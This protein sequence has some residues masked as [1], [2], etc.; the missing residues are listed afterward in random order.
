MAIIDARDLPD[1]SELEADLVIIGAGMAGIAI[2]TELAGANK[3]VAVLEGGG[4]DLDREQQTLYAGSGVMRAP[5]HEDTNIDDYLWQSRVRALG[6]SGHVWGGKCVPLDESD[7]AARDWLPNTGW[8]MTRA[9]LQPY[10]D[11]ACGLLEI[12]LF[13]GS[14]DRPREEGR[15]PIVVNGARE[16]FSAPRYFSPVSGGADRDKFDRFRTAFAEAPNVNV[17]L[18]ANVTEIRRR[19]GARRVSSLGVACLNGR[20][21]TARGRSYVLATGGIENVRLLL[22]S[23]LGN[24][25]DQLGRN[26]MGH[27]TFGAFADDAP[28]SILA[29]SEPTQ[30]AGLYT[31][32][33]RD[34]FHCVL[35]ATLE[36]QRRFGIGNF[37]A[38]LF[39]IES[40]R[41]DGEQA[42]FRL[43]AAVDRGESAGARPL[44]T[45]FMAEHMPN[46]Q[47]RITLDQANVDELGL[48]RVKLDWLYSERDLRN[49]EAGV[50]AF[51]QVFGEA[52]VG[53]V[54]WPVA[55]ERLLANFSPSRH[56]MGATRMSVDPEHGV[57]D[58]HG[59]L[60]E[61]RN[62][63]VAG[64]S[65][66]PTSGIANPTLTL[67]ALAL[68]MSDQLKGELG[69]RS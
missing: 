44:H 56:H 13:D 54:C 11:R 10:Y 52:N 38:T 48:P 4:R 42:I 53:R 26:F 8:P 51:A 25:S 12:P 2:A 22:A 18:H 36:G 7:F 15:P 21:H 59:R 60:H 32:N 6:G 62:F 69:V 30:A 40:P 50:V 14:F 55:R 29:L 5:D 17:Y 68:R 46:R 41:P 47:S 45:Y 57:V 39:D 65:V 63:Y 37:T 35:A 31:D 33:A 24:E 58:P 43:A 16:F 20:R 1:G 23:N 34:R 19:R 64:C 61:A 9:Q 66:F 3:S 67:I 49:L 27:V 28:N